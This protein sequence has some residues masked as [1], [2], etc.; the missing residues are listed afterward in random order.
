MIWN[1]K[2]YSTVGGVYTEGRTIAK[3]ANGSWDIKEIKEDP[4]HTF[5]VARAFLDQYL[6][7]ADDYTVPKSGEITT[8]CW[9]ETVIQD[10]DFL[11]AM[12][13]IEATKTTMFDYETEG[14]FMLTDNQHMRELYFAYDE[15][16]VATEY[17]GYMGKVN[18]K[19]VITT[20]ISPD[21]HNPDGSPKP[22]SVSCYS[23][24]DQFSE[25]LEKYFS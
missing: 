25:M 16:P 24:P 9:N 22:Y 14:I 8:V 5:V 15:C 20:A 3:S 17:K 13:E 4:S 19:W 2:E 23:I 6:Y 1:G 21:Q 18:G 12:A 11:K 10:T 7:V